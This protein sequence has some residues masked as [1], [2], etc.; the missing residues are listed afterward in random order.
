MLVVVLSHGVYLMS[1]NG[2]YTFA[3]FVVFPSVSLVLR[4]LARLSPGYRDLLL[5]VEV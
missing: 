3:R 5:A 2:L 4:C 1:C